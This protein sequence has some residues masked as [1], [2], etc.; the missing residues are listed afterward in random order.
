MTGSIYG[1]AQQQRD[2]D[3]EEGEFGAGRRARAREAGGVPR[4]LGTTHR[5]SRRFSDAPPCAWLPGQTLTRAG[6]PAPRRQGSDDE[7]EMGSPA[8]RGV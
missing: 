2:A 8:K 7:T 3:V 1:V 6:T 5:L 4:S